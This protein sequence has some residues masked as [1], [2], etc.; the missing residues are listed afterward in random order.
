MFYF[1]GGQGWFSLSRWLCFY[2]I[3]N[4]FG[5]VFLIQLVMFDA[6]GCGIN[7][8]AFISRLI[9]LVFTVDIVDDP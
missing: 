3:M 9:E 4:Y 6:C 7:H 8:F 5:C 2:R 1:L